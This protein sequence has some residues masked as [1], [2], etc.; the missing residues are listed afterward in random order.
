MKWLPMTSEPFEI[1]A[2]GMSRL[3]AWATIAG[4]VLAELVIVALV[5]AVLLG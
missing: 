4:L 3:A 5:V 1:D 2:Q